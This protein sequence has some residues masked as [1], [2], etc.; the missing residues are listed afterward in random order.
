MCVRSI[1][2]LLSAHVTFFSPS[3]AVIAEQG[4]FNEE[5]DLQGGHA[6]TDYPYIA[7]VRTAPRLFDFADDP[8]GAHDALP[9]GRDVAFQRVDES[10]MGI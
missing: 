5:T 3:L 8:V 10:G 2:D 7:T 9:D 1:E 6:I 4:C